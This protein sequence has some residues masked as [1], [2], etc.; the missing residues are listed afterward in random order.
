MNPYDSDSDDDDAPN[1][2]VGGDTNHG[3]HSVGG[4]TGSN[5]P[6]GAYGG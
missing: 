3:A 5:N 2:A 4:D 1:H 6:H